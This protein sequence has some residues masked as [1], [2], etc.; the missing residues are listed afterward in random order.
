MKRPL[1][2]AAILILA[3]S[4]VSPGKPL[5]ALVAVGHPFPMLAEITLDTETG[6]EWLDLDL[7]VGLSI[8]E[9]EGGAGGW[10]AQGWRHASTAE[11][12]D[13]FER[14]LPPLFPPALSC[15]IWSTDFPTMISTESAETFHRF[16]GSTG[17]SYDTLG[18]GSH[19]FTA[20]SGVLYS[21]GV[22]EGSQ[23]AY[24]VNSV[25]EFT[26][27]SDSHP[28]VGHFLV[29]DPAAPGL[30]TLGAWARL[31]LVGLLGIVG[32]LRTMR[33]A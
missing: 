14:Y 30:P 8:E 18:V 32:A 19:A 22:I 29:R 15:P 25:P 2:A 28:N 16:F 9:V 26:S 17:Y 5:A 33:R 27:P 4:L 11:V 10:A 6:L 1:I 20:P 3:G 7:T 31:G 13:L 23:S 24:W 12:C 21:G